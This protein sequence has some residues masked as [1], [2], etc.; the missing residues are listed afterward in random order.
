VA[1]VLVVAVLLLLVGCTTIRGLIDTEQAL[2]RAGFTDVD[3]NFSTEKGFD[4]VDVD[5]RPPPRELADAD[6]DA[7]EAAT[8]VWTTF[9]LRFDL[10]RLKL[11]RPGEPDVVT[12][13]Y[14]ELEEI[15]GPRPAGLDDKELGDDVVRAGLG[16]ALVL[17]IGGFLFLVAVVLAIVLGLRASRRRKAVVPPPWPPVPR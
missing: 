11:L 14:S 17:A 8:V 16:I 15:L 13:T 12:Y 9:P 10:L 4:R 7:R 2:D 3:V 1:T 5:L 6:A